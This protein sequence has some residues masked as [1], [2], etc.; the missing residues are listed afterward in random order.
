M[1]GASAYY[2]NLKNTGAWKNK[3]S[4]N[5]Q[6]IVLTTQLFELKTEIS[7]LLANKAPPKQTETAAPTPGS[8]YVF[9][10][11]RLKKV[12]NKVEHNVIERD[13]KT[14]Y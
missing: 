12:D 2:V 6:I 1:N 3:L 5:T 7:K 9:E 10:L 4:H 8:R 13:E 14:W 11:W